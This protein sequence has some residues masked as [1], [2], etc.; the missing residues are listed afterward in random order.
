MLLLNS[1]DLI[2]LLIQSKWFGCLLGEKKNY[3]RLTHKLTE[4]PTL[5]LFELLPNTKNFRLSPW[6]S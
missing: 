2:L 6:A 4:V 1:K 3:K 5:I